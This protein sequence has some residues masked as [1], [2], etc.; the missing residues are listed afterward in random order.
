[1]IKFN[2]EFNKKL[3][4]YNNDIRIIGIDRGEKHLAF[5]SVIDQQ[6]NIIEQ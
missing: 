1:V 5:Y 6:Q 3:I 2:Q 4:N